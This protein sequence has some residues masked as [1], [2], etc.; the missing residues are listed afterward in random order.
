M[1]LERVGEGRFELVDFN[2]DDETRSAFLQDPEGALRTYLEQHGEVVNRVVIT[3]PP[4]EVPRHGY[5]V[6]HPPEEKS[7]WI[8]G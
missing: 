1:A 8:C 4:G 6:V 5:H 2:L 3:A 7:Q